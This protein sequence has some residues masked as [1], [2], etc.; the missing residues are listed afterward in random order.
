MLNRLSHPVA[1]RIIPLRQVPRTEIAA[2]Q[3]DIVHM[4]KMS[5]REPVLASTPITVRTTFSP[6][7]LFFVNTRIFFFFNFWLFSLLGQWN[8]DVLIYNAFNVYC[9]L[10][11]FKEKMV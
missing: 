5:T 4:P 9:P 10:M 2:S 6:H 8:P 1:P 7:G 3:C 11:L